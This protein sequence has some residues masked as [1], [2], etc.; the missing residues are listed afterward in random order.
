MPTQFSSP[1]AAIYVELA[2]KK[3]CT[4]RSSGIVKECV[5]LSP[6]G[7]VTSRQKKEKLPPPEISEFL[8]SSEENDNCHVAPEERGPTTVT[9]Q[10]SAVINGNTSIQQNPSNPTL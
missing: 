7:L 6:L 2:R 10:K 9:E 3:M 1:R 4:K 8:H 5:N